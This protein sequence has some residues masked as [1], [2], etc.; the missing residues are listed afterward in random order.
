ME[1]I[2][3]KLIQYIY[4]Y[5]LWFHRFLFRMLHACLIFHARIPRSFTFGN[6]SHS[7]LILKTND[8]LKHSGVNGAKNY[9]IS[10]RSRSW[11]SPFIPKE[12]TFSLWTES[13]KFPF[14]PFQHMIPIYAQEHRPYAN[15]ESQILIPPTF[16]KCMQHAVHNLFRCNLK[17]RKKQ[18]IINKNITK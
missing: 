17:F 5:L 4:R 11:T 2:A 14:S 13:D 3:L 16:A 7:N 15:R 6:V 18:H 1:M 9:H 8:A 12:D 10:F